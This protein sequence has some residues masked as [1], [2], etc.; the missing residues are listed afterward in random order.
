MRAGAATLCLAM[1]AA[2]AAAVFQLRPFE[3]V[4]HLWA[5][6]VA[7]ALVGVG[8]LVQGI[9]GLRPRTAPERFAAIGALG[10]ALA[11][12]TMVSASFAVGPPHALP[13]SPGQ[14]TPVRP[15]ASVLVLFP[16]L[17][18]A[19]LRGDAAPDSVTILAG[20]TR[21]ELAPGT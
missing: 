6:A 21:T 5:F 2:T 17:T 15:G 11:C 14:V 8:L 9:V 13:G 18:E 20:G 10:G 19:Q 16:A 4:F 3:P 7:A 12:A 1:V